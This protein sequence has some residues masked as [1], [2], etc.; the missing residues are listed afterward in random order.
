[1]R[2][3]ISFALSGTDQSSQ[4]VQLGSVT[5]DCGSLEQAESGAAFYN[6]HLNSDSFA[7]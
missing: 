7:F 6:I 5:L 1:M 3:K 2:A 4:D